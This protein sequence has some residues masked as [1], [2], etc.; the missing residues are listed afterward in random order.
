MHKNPTMIEARLD[1]FVVQS[2][3]PSVYRRTV[4]LT[5]TSW[6]VPD[7]PIPF[8]QAIPN[9]FSEFTVGQSWGLPWGTTW[10]HITGEVPETWDTSGNT[11]EILI[12][13]GFD[14]A[15]I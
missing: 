10:F 6:E 14:L 11:V 9:Q 4:P 1:R 7:E 2:L 15:F 5:V 13:L 3:L 8:A 12:D